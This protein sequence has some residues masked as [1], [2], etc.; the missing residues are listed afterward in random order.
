MDLRSV[1]AQYYGHVAEVQLFS[2][3]GLSTDN[4]VVLK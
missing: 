3:E 1:G 4:G 2:D